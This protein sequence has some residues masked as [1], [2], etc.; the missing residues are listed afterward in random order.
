[1]QA[2][3]CCPGDVSILSC[4][5]K[6]NEISKVFMGG[7]SGTT[8]GEVM[9]WFLR[10]KSVTWENHRIIEEPDWKKL[11]S[12]WYATWNVGCRNDGRVSRDNRIRQL[13]I[14]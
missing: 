3:I 7:G 8:T 6:V 14:F 12:P 2:I 1:M 13:S 4:L 10:K 11:A 5:T 9:G